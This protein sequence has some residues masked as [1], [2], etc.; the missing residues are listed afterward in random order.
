MKTIH[1]LIAVILIAGNVYAN[2]NLDNRKAIKKE[3]AQF[4]KSDRG[5]SAGVST[6]NPPTSLRGAGLRFT[7]NKC[8]IADMNG[9]LCPNVLYKGETSNCFVENEK[10]SSEQKNSID[11]SI[12]KHQS[13]FVENKGQ[14]TDMANNPVPFVLFKIEAPGLDMYITE[15]GLT[16]VFLKLEED[17]AEKEGLTQTDSREGA[18]GIPAYKDEKIK[19]EWERIDMVLKGAAIKKKNIIKEN[20]STDFKQYFL[21]HCP[22][23]I[24]DVHTF[25]QIT[26]K[27]I[28]PGIDWVLYNSNIK[29][30]KYDFVVH[31]GAK[32]RDIELVYS[33]RKKLKITD[34]GNIEIQTKHGKL[35]EQAPESFLSNG[36]S[37]SFEEGRGEMIESKFK[38]LSTELN[39]Y[40]GYDI[41]IDFDFPHISQL[42]AGQAGLT[43]DLIIDPQ[44]I[45]ATFYG[46]NSI[47]GPMSIETDNNGNVF[48]VGYTSSTDLP[49]QNPGGLSYFQGTGGATGA[50]FILKFN[51]TGLLLWST[52]YAGTGGDG[53]WSVATD[54]SGNVFV[55]GIT[56]SNDLPTQNPGAGAYFQG[57]YAGGQDGFILKFNNTGVRLFATYYGGSGF[58]YFESIATDASGNVFLAGIT[59]SNNLPTQNP[60][61]GAYF[62]GANAGGLDAFILK[63]NNAGVCLWATYYGGSGDE[64]THYTATDAGS[65][66]FITGW[67]A[68]GNF[69][70][71]NPGAGAYFNGTNA[72]GDDV[73]ILKFNNSGVCIWAT[74]Y[75][76]SSA[77]W[78]HS[79]TTDTGGNV[80]VAGWTSSN[81]LPTQNPAGG[82]Y[83][84]ATKAGGFDVFI[85][86]FTNAG[87]RLWATYYGGSSDESFS[88]ADN[89]DVDNCGNV[90]LGFETYSSNIP[91][92]SSCDVGYFDNS[93]NGGNGD[94]FIA[95]FSNS[96]ILRWATYLGGDGGDFRTPIVVDVNNNLFVSGEWINA[97]TD[98]SYPLSTPGGGTY[99][100]GTFNFSHDGLM[101]KFTPVKLNVTA[102][103]TQST[104]CSSSCN[105][106]ITLSPPSGG[107]TLTYLWSN[108]AM[109]KNLSSLCAGTYSVTISDAVFCRTL[110]LNNLTIT[111]STAVAPTLSFTSTSITCGNNNGSI[112]ATATGGSPGYSYNWSNGGTTSQI[113]NLSAQTYT[114]T[115]TDNN[116]CSAISTVV[117]TANTTPPTVTAVSNGNITCTSST[118]TL[119]GTSAGNTMVWNGGTLS[120]ATNPATVNAAGT[121][122]VTATDGNGCTNTATINVISIPPL[123]GQFTKG[124]ASCSGCGCMEW[125]MVTATGGTP[126]YTYFWPD[127]YINRYKNHLC[128]GTYTINITDKNGC[129]V[130]VSLTAP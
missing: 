130:N 114:V 74:Y 72:G 113:T 40:G 30:F 16:Y 89:L 48:V 117:I 84:Q 81:N 23:G 101:V 60:G 120:N 18:K 37:L 45:W 3:Q 54:P 67:T 13:R 128:P 64:M 112:T 25:Q 98:A 118:A 15:K 103:I 92:Q 69:P 56:G 59:S 9:S 119:T 123:V 97:I 7:P 31:P 43:S 108:G 102:T 121:Y 71:Q 41:T 38:L 85:L 122:T 11:N 100:D 106:T 99:Y 27:D 28:Y 24:T 83:F 107:C 53:A 111:Q 109:T 86:K 63:F 104:N 80:F 17:E 44:L 105:G 2:G 66:V 35:T 5:T 82:T 10:I 110:V 88:S 91:I 93:Y 51:N 20:A 124:T 6:G 78:A 87:V 95:L 94:Q 70:T 79:I 129:S 90:Y 22:D 55:A 115:V 127:G 49:T 33:S 4:S 19:V 58:D 26:I 8:Q 62:Q 126:P 125:I 77:D 52:F 73:F 21:A 14:M 39:I 34:D 57:A 61:A 96:G 68:S 46:G 29:G 75:G 65:N 76:G 36:S 12:H 47:D 1:P 42:P 50:A 32:P 116:S